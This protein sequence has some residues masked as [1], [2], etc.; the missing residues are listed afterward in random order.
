MKWRVMLLYLI[1]FSSHHIYAEQ[2][3][4]E[5]LS[6]D[7]I[8]CINSNQEL[9]FAYVP[10]NI[11]QA[12]EALYKLDETKASTIFEDA[13]PWLESKLS[14]MPY[15]L[16]TQLTTAARCLYKAN[17]AHTPDATL[18]STIMQELATYQTALAE[19]KALITITAPKT[20]GCGSAKVI[21]D[22]LVKNDIHAQNL[23]V[24]GNEQIDG[25]LVVNGCITANCVKFPLNGDGFPDNLFFVFSAS[26]P[27]RKVVFNIQ[28]SPSTT[29]TIMTAPTVNR[30]F[31]TPDIDGTALVAQ[32]GTNEVFIGGPTGPLHGS[33]SGIQYSTTFPS[34]A[35]I[36]F[37]QYGNNTGVPGVSTFKSRSATIGGLAPVQPGDVIFRDTAVGVTSNLSIPLSGLISINVPANGVPA[38]QGYIATEYELQLVSLD[39]PVNG[40]RVVFKISSEGV[41]QMLESTSAGPHTTVPSGVVTLA[42]TIA[43]GGT[44]IVPN[45]KI[46]ANARILLT[47]QPS[48]A[49]T[50]FIYVSNI[51]LNTGFTITSTAGAADNGV[52]VYYQMYIPLP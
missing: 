13:S 26:D 36:R 37:N 20:R 32:T 1:L 14:I 24:S 17:E 12:L 21:C 45:S 5:L 34:R 40:R 7:A 11:T 35:Q 52:K 50:G 41:L 28:G 4:G 6:D 25:N 47:V 39:G 48:Q 23:Y 19:K 15:D 51:T 49:P 22:L 9:S 27:S 18:Y 30:T 8:T 44:F 33:N 2:K 10:S 31:I 43:G 29:T 3:D 38:G 42:T 16:A 46:P